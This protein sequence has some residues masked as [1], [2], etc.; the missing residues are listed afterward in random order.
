MSE[1][2]VHIYKAT[3]YHLARGL[4]RVDNDAGILDIKY[5]DYSAW[6]YFNIKNIKD[7]DRGLELTISE[8]I[9]YIEDK[10]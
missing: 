5:G 2:K 6:F 7:L 10:I 9:K 8:L 3:D 1:V 4:L